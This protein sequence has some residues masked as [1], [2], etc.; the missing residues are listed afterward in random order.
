MFG[1]FQNSEFNGDISKWNVSN[2]TTMF[3][4]FYRSRFNGDISKWDV[5][6]VKYWDMDE[7]FDY[8]PLQ[9]NPP[10]WYRNRK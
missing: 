6:N 10:A 3:R 1:M 5:S 4:M 7:M 9:N 2:V 8:C